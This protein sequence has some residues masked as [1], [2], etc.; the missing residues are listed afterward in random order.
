[1]LLQVGGQRNWFQSDLKVVLIAVVSNR[2]VDRLLDIQGAGIK[3]RQAF[4]KATQ[5]ELAVR[6]GHGHFVAKVPISSDFD[7]RIGNRSAGHINHRARHFVTP[8][9][10]NPQKFALIRRERVNIFSSLIDVIGM[11]ES[12]ESPGQFVL[13]NARVHRIVEEFERPIRTARGDLDP[14]P[15]GAEGG[16]GPES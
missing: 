12:D 8:L 2:H 10:D 6:V 9:Q 15:S 3:H 14:A 4:A 13:N 1:M 16:I 5:G 7:H 11:G